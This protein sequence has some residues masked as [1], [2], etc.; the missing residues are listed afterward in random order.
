VVDSEMHA[1]LIDFGSASLENPGYPNYLDKFQGTV[2][3]CPPEVLRG[4]K[5]K[6]KPGTSVSFNESS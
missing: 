4:E 6:G 5:F 1:K 2:Q 3:Y